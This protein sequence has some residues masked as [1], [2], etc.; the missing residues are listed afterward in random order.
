MGFQLLI[1]ITAFESL[2]FVLPLQTRDE[3]KSFSVRDRQQPLQLRLTRKNKSFTPAGLFY[4]HS[5]DHT[6]SNNQITAEPEGSINLF[7]HINV[8]SLTSCNLEAWETFLGKAVDTYLFKHWYERWRAVVSKKMPLYF[9]VK[10]RIPEI[11]NTYSKGLCDKN[12]YR[13]VHS[14]TQM[15]FWCTSTESLW[16]LLINWNTTVSVLALLEDLSP[17]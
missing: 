14:I 3:S 11:L 15:I 17:L 10:Y 8:T 9:S 5:I 6:K 12:H 1:L 16:I 2:P 4:L 7:S 13:C